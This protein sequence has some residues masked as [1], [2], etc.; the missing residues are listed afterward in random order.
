MSPNYWPYLSAA[1]KNSREP[2]L[3]KD[4]NPSFGYLMSET[5][6]RQIVKNA[7]KRLGNKQITL[8]NDFP[9][10]K[11]SL[12]PQDIVIFLQ[13][14][15]CKRNKGNNGVSR[16]ETIQL[17]VDLGGAC[18]DKQ[19]KNHLDYLI[20]MGWLDKLKRDGRVVSA[21]G[22]TTERSQIS[23]SHQYHW[24]CLIESECK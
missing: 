7:L 24:H 18:S 20:R 10:L 23:V 22:K 8:V 3:S 13:D 17:I 4:D 2:D 1:L 19:V 16:K 14:I 6:P 15:I 12:L 5:V 11:R 9:I 21:Q